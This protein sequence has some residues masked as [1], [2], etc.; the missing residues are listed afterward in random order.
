MKVPYSWLTS[1]CDPGLSPSDAGD[2]LAMHSIELERISHVG[3][4][5]AEG[6][7]VGRVVSAE[8]H[9]NADRLSV[10]EVDTGDGTRTIVCGA[11]NVAVGQAVPVALPGAVM[12]GGQELGQAKLRGVVSDGMI[13]SEAELELGDDAGGIVVLAA[14]GGPEAGTP[15]ADVV[16]VSEPILEL[17]PTSNRVD[18]F[19]VYGVGR[20]LHAV[21]GADLAPP[22]WEG[23]AEAAGDGEASD[24]ASVRV[25][26]PELCPRFTARVFTDVTIGPS[27]LWLKARLIG[28]GMRPIYNVVDITNYVMLMTAQPLHSFDLDKVP[29]GE[30][31]V[32]TARE[33]ETMTTLDG[34]ERRFDADA[35]LVCDRDGPTGVAGIMGSQVSEV[36]EDTTRVLLEVAT[37][38]GPNILRTSRNLALRSDASNRFEKQLHPEMAIRAQRIASQLMVELCGAKLVPGTI[39][40]AA[41][42]PERHRVRLRPAR[43]EELLGMEVEPDRCVTYLERLDFEVSADGE[44]LEALVP[45]HRHYD[46]TREADLV[47]EVGRIHGYAEHLPATLPRAS[48]QTGRLSRSQSLR[49]RAEDVLRDLGFEGVVTLSLT[50]AGMPGRLRLP[51]DDARAGTIRVSN[52]LSG[53]HSELRTT[54]LGSLLDVVRYNRAHG[55]ERVALYE[56]GRACLRE[57]P[58]SAGDGPLAGVFAGDEPAPAYEPHRIACLAAGRLHPGGWRAEEV[59]ADF[60]AIKGVLEALAAQLGVRVAVEAASEPFLHPGRAAAVSIG[61]ERVGWIGEIHP[62][63]CAAW[64]LESAAGFELDLAPLVAASPQGEETYEDVITYPAVHQDIAVVVPE[65]VSA[66]AVTGAVTEAA[67]ELLRSAEIFDLYRGEQVG[68][69]RKSLAL[70]LEFRAADRT[71]TDA[72]VAERRQAITEAIAGIGGSLRE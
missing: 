44:E 7:V 32:R 11:P 71:L 70:Q 5:S 8:K 36:S 67:G 59:D 50:D 64:D 37:W 41:E 18:C 55:A 46:V 20:E 45:F 17:E 72:E 24:L 28:A 60:F 69:G 25:E 30:I 57:R 53:D 38:N 63:V 21:T 6:F 29:G 13:L 34:V 33:G 52:P 31:I 26:V 65:E 42:I 22:P 1:Y 43:A 54:L 12:P 23:D 14:D 68:E 9:P 19:G 40:E 66:A 27:P 61:G 62:R 15:L 16:S 51:D 58:A 49:R 48:D 47:E 2:V 35:V 4:P 3:P 39:D 10:C 56:S